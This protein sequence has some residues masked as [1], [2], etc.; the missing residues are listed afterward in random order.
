MSYHKSMLPLGSLG[1]PSGLEEAASWSPSVTDPDRIRPVNGTCGDAK[2]IQGA[3]KDLGYYSGAIDGILGKG[4]VSAITKFSSAK[5]I[6][7]I[8]WPTAVFCNA[9]KDSQTAFVR[10]QYDLKHPQPVG[11]DG[12]VQPVG[13]GGQV[14]PVGPG[15]Q[16]A[17]PGGGG[18]ESSTRNYLLIGGFAVAAILGVVMIYAISKS[19]S[20]SKAEAALCTTV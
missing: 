12:Q 14:Q 18:E 20:P 6:G 19:D 16:V 13:P 9:L 8:S 7:N 1:W 2:A 3:L 10:A 4:S 17:P 15:G 11:P 5:G